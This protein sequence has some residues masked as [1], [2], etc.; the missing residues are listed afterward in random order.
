MVM[1]YENHHWVG[2]R[3]C[4]ETAVGWVC[5]GVQK[6]Q[7]DG[8]TMVHESRLWA[9][10]RWCVKTTAEQEGDGAQK[11]WEGRFVMVPQYHHGA[12][13]RWCA[14]TITGQLVDSVQKPQRV[15]QMRD[16]TE[17]PPLGRCAMA[18]DHGGWAHGCM[19]IW[20]AM[21]VTILNSRNL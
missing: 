13:A 10:A 4:K 6:P 17:R 5:S 1:V 3:W 12:G 2:V 7:P 8:K 20:N 15:R 9:G 21:I 18:R 11:P 16:G 14:K 19:G